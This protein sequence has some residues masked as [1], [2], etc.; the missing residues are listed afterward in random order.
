MNNFTKMIP[1]RLRTSLTC[2]ILAATTFF[3]Q[4]C[5]KDTAPVVEISYLSIVN[6][7]PTL[8]TFNAYVDQTKITNA[9]PLSF[10]AAVG[11]FQATP[12]AHTVK[13]TTA[14]STDPLISKS[15][16]LEAN[17]AYSLFLIN[18]STNMDYL[19]TPDQ[20]NNTASAKA[21]VRFVNLSPD[22]PALNLNVKDVATALIPDQAYKAVSSFIETEAK[23]YTFQLKNKANGNAV[24][25]NDLTFELK[26]G[27]TYT[28][29]AVGMVTAA[30]GDQ[31]IQIKVVTNQ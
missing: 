18:K 13:F 27:K 25:E 1:A 22:A 7:T 5:S 23:S 28:V 14:S 24:G 9:G 29:M 6:A 20:I 21:F 16:S 15:V 4:S 31:K 12:G 11:Y 3:M 17:K 2:S 19:L 8:A 26:A 30:E 10:G